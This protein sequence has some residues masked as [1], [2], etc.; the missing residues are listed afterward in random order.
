[1]HGEMAQKER[2]AIM[3]EFRQGSSRVLITTEY[4]FYRTFL[5]FGF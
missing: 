4:V 2:D 1:M 3:S 5:R